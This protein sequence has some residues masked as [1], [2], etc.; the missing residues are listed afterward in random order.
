[1]QPDLRKALFDASEKPLEP[2]DLEIGM[3]AALHQHA[4][5][6][7]LKGLRNLLVD[8]FE[9]E[10]VALVRARIGLAGPGQRAIEGAEG[11]VLG[12]VV[13][14][15]DVA[16]DDVGNHALGMQ[17]AAHSVG[18][19][20]QPDQ[21][22]GLKVIE[23]LLARDRHGSILAIQLRGVALDRGASLARRKRK[24]PRVRSGRPCVRARLDAVETPLNRTKKS[25]NALTKPFRLFTA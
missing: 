8:F 15:V 3:N 12:A 23:S 25:R 19:E 14:V 21:V 4:G 18:F 2:V 20:S 13:G 1:M 9:V 17:A 22:G 11:A 24:M 10:N 7:H 16:I 5:A 6:A